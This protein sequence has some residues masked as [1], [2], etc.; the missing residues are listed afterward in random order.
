MKKVIILSALLALLCGCAGNNNVSGSLTVEDIAWNQSGDETSNIMTYDDIKT[1][2]E[3]Y[4]GTDA[5][6]T[7]K[8]VSED[9]IVLSVDGYMVEP[10]ENGTINLRK[11]P[12]RKITLKSGETIEVVSQ[13]MDAGTTLNLKYE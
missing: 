12:L 3:V 6:I 11:D 7:V 5:V 13:T 8:S 10:N 2:D 1:G 4:S 9:R